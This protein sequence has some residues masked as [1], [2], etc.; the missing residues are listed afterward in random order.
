MEAMIVAPKDFRRFIVVRLFYDRVSND[1][2]V[3]NMYSTLLVCQSTT[4][5]S[6]FN[7]A[8]NLFTVHI[9]IFD[10]HTTCVPRSITF[11]SHYI[12]RYQANYVLILLV[13]FPYNI[14]YNNSFAMWV[15]GL[16]ILE[17]S[18]NDFL[19]EMRSCA[20]VICGSCVGVCVERYR[21]V[22]CFLE[23]TKTKQKRTVFITSKQLGISFE[24]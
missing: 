13:F 23:N 12:M 8:N 5:S 9:W 14:I 20:W 16:G 10:I 3:M 19:W 6:N 4:L 7:L 15:Q 17:S 24:K 21:E 2:W 1:W 18:Y 11:R 22:G